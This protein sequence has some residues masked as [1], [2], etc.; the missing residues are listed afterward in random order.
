MKAEI[1]PKVSDVLQALGKR[2]V[3]V[4]SWPAK[5]IYAKDIDIV[6]PDR[7]PENSRNP[8]MDKLC[9]S[10]EVD[11]SAIGHLFVRCEE[12]NIEVFEDNGW[13]VDDPDKAKNQLSYLQARRRSSLID[14]Y[15]IECRAVL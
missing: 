10:F 2:F 6:V 15:G 13:P 4:G 8:I 9:E 12:H 5:G 11:S 1:M 7:G 3:I 14:C